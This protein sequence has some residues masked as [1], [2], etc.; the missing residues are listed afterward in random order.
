MSIF[1]LFLLTT[2]VPNLG[3]ALGIL[4]SMSIAWL[5]IMSFVCV[6]SEFDGDCV[7]FLKKHIKK[8]IIVF[9]A[10]LL[11]NVPM[12]SERQMLL[13]AGGYAATNNAEIKKLPTNAAK[14]VNAWLDA[15]TEAAESDKKK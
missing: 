11:L 12:P 2:I 9:T 15:A 14:A 7:S 4:L 3:V 5:C 1:E 13:V 6:I 8:S 10:L